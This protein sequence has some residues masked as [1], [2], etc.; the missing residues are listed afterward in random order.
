LGALEIFCLL[1]LLVGSS[2]ALI[3]LSGAIVSE[4]SPDVAFS[5]LMTLPETTDADAEDGACIAGGRLLLGDR[6]ICVV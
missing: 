6:G 5:C 1:A 4:A 2:S 3:F